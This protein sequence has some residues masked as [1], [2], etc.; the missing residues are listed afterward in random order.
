MNNNL[1]KF[2][3]HHIKP[4]AFSLFFSAAMM[5]LVWITVTYGSFSAV[6]LAAGICAVLYSVLTLAALVN[7]FR[8]NKLFEGSA[9]EVFSV[10]TQKKIRM[11]GVAF[12]LPAIIYCGIFAYL[13]K[14][15]DYSESADLRIAS[16]QDFEYFV[17]GS[18][19]I[20]DF[21][22]AQNA[23]QLP[24]DE[25]SAVESA[26][27]FGP[28][29]TNTQVKIKRAWSPKRSSS[30]HHA[31]VMFSVD[32]D[33]NVSKV[34]LEKCSGSVDGDKAALAAVQKAS[35]L[36][37]LPQG[38]PANVDISFTFDYNVFN[39]AGEMLDESGVPVVSDKC[40]S[41]GCDTFSSASSCDAFSSS[42]SADGE[43]VVVNGDR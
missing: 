18:T 35:P 27:D 16:F 1:V 41:A 39:G 26:V 21:V 17:F 23:P 29:M 37:N 36:D 14:S 43:Y 34:R 15:Y 42:S 12:A 13:V 40:S 24:D 6:P 9:A 7:L 8:G 32:K 20:L 11:A 10:S 28:Y 31:V 30:S 2:V 19:K 38:A 25:S 5:S 22:I 33:G 4:L 3:L